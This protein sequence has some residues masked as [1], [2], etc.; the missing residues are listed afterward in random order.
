MR[1]PTIYD[2]C[3]PS[4][5]VL[6]GRIRDEGFAADL[7]QVLTGKVPELYRN[8][9]LFFSPALTATWAASSGW[10]PKL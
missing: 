4:Q 6:A 3:R 1:P 9:T 8:P 2:L 7:S 10:T 5:D